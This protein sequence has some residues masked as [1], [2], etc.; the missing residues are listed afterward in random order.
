MTNILKI[1][2]F[3][4]LALV[5]TQSLPNDVRSARK[6]QEA[7]ELK[8]KND[9]AALIR[10]IEAYEPLEG[11]RS[12][13]QIA[14][15]NA[16]LHGLFGATIGQSPTKE[17]PIQECPPVFAPTPEEIEYYCR[18]AARQTSQTPQRGPRHATAKKLNLVI[19]AMLE[20]STNDDVTIT[21]KEEERESWT[22]E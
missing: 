1:I 12:S 9:L 3:A 18:L 17:T 13:T 21:G 15:L 11:R 8:I 4:G 14:V 20:Q 6:K 2:A 5:T 16:E 7:R 22:V 10:D 19:E